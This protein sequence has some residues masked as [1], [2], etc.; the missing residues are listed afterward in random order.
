MPDEAR[1]NEQPNRADFNVF[2]QLLA[3]AELGA[4][5]AEIFG[6]FSSRQNTTSLTRV[7]NYMRDTGPS[8]GSAS[9][10]TPNVDD[11][12]T[13]TRTND[14]TV[15]RTTRSSAQ[16]SSRGMH[17]IA[18]DLRSIPLRTLTSPQWF[19]DANRD[20]VLGKPMSFVAIAACNMLPPSYPNTKKRFIILHFGHNLWA[21]LYVPR[22]AELYFDAN[23]GFN[24]ADG[25]LAHF[26][27]VYGHESRHQ[28]LLRFTE[29]SEVQRVNALDAIKDCAAL[30]LRLDAEQSD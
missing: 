22:S 13:T 3:I 12:Q 14:R 30:N 27:G 19:I 1:S 29:R 2:N 8:S 7:M 26:R 24:F 23:V 20:K 25:T 10:R 15:A 5:S 18:V 28:R 11:A 9:R 16:S 17:R 21:I 6:F 4:P